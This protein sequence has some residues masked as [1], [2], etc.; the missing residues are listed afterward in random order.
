MERINM[1]KSKSIKLRKWHFLFVGSLMV[2][3]SAFLWYWNWR[4]I[5]LPHPLRPEHY[6]MLA[7]YVVGLVVLGLFIFR[8]TKAQVTV[9][10]V[11]LIIV[12]LVMALV[13]AWIYR[14]YPYF[15]EVLRP[16]DVVDYDPAYIVDWERYFLTPVV[17]S[18]HIGMLLL[19]VE[20]LVMFLVRTPGD[21]PG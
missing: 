17:Y 21:E 1:D 4:T 11:W 19:F 10:L 16:I 9:F 18:V 15:F 7:V 2:F 8:L 12:N 14:S 20:S 3:L 13:T 5:G 6:L